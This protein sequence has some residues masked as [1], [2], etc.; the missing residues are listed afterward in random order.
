MQQSNP[1]LELLRASAALFCCALPCAGCTLHALSC[2]PTIVQLLVCLLLVAHH[3]AL[4]TE[5]SVA[6]AKE[7]GSIRLWM[8]YGSTSTLF[9]I[10]HYSR[11]GHFHACMTAMNSLVN[12]GFMC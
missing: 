12:P 3:Q 11:C 7:H 2:M 9:D 8:D 1:M 4:C 10:L 6:K 5:A